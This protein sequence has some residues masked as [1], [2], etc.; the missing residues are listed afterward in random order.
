MEVQVHL[1]N[2]DKGT[3]GTVTHVAVLLN[4]VNTELLAKGG[5]GGEEFIDGLDV[6]LLHFGKFFH[7]FFGLMLSCFF[8][9]YNGLFWI[10]QM[11]FT[12][13]HFRGRP[14]PV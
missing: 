13:F 11:F 4:V 6:G 3:N 9:K 2:T 5:L 12:N 7:I 1:V 14:D 8:Y 10:S